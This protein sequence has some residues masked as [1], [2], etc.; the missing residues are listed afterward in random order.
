MEVVGQ[1][2][3]RLLKDLGPQKARIPD[4]ISS[5]V[6]KEC[7]KSFSRPLKKLFRKSMRQGSVARKWKR[8]NVVVISKRPISI[9]SILKDKKKKTNE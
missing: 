7:L 2:I 9:T 4:G 5:F 8:A 1:D 6:H 3:S